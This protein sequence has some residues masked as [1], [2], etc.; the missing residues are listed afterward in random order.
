[1]CGCVCACVTHTP[2][3]DLFIET[4]AS[5]VISGVDVGQSFIPPHYLCKA[6]SHPQSLHSLL[7]CTVFLEK[8]CS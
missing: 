4:A 7:E 3:S 8:V 6:S 2:C 5:N 1:M